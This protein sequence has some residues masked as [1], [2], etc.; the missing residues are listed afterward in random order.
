MQLWS[1]K[2]K[3]SGFTIVELLIVI[4]VI[5]ILAAITVV[6]YNGIQNRATDT[7]RQTDVKAMQTALE[8]YYID[9]GYY[10]PHNVLNG[11]PGYTF[12]KNN[13]VGMDLRAMTAPGELEGTSSFTGSTG[14][15]TANR[16]A[17]KAY[18]DSTLVTLGYGVEAQTYSISWIKVSAGNAIQTTIR[19][20]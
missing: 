2:S 18:T 6:A 7:E 3:K 14:G 20:K 8:V 5:G 15:L 13:F 19:S 17:Y 11:A 12:A 16:Y 10:P 9:H 1:K 4:V